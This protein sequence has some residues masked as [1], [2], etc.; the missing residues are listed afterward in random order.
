MN[1]PMKS[2]LEMAAM[3]KAFKMLVL[4]AILML[5][6]PV[7]SQDIPAPPDPPRLVNDLAGILEPQQV[8]YLERKVVA[9]DDSTSTQIAIVI[10]PTLGGYSREDYADRLGEKWGVGRKGKDNGVLILVKPKTDSE[11]GEARI[12]VGYGLEGVLTDVL[13]GRIV[14]NEMI[15]FFKEGDYFSGIN[16]AVDLVMGLSQGEFTADQVKGDKQGSIAGFVII[17]IFVIFYI[18]F[19]NRSRRQFHTGST[20]PSLWSTIWMAS[21]LGGRGG[22]S[23]WG[24]F[25]SGGGSFGGGGGFGGFGGG[26]FGGGGAGGSW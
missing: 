6:S 9:F 4:P 17:L 11:K 24:D 25:N 5:A 7:V 13:M 19:R 18:I 10:V 14:D 22:G 16:R 12:S 21:M 23:S 20:G 15:P 3:N 2:P 8:A 26:S 1:F